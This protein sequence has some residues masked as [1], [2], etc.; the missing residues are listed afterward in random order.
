MKSI[1]L[2]LILMWG[3]IPTVSGVGEDYK[4]APKRWVKG[5]VIEML[6]EKAIENNI[7]PTYLVKLAMC[8]SSASS[9][10]QSKFT[11]PYGREQSFG[12]FQI[13]TKV[14]KNVTVS[15]AKDPLFNAEWAITEIKKGKASRHWVHC[16]KV[17]L[18]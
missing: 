13:H 6:K 17:A 5:E 3:F 9:T 1:I 16:H 18:K 8:E 10:M 14:H 4:Q 7:N 15:Q 11:Q 12:L 2:S